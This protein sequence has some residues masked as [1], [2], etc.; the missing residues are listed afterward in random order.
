MS[1][2]KSKDKVAIV[3]LGES[4]SGKS[5]TFYE[6]FNRRLQS[7]YK[8]LDIN[9]VETLV[10]LKNTSFEEMGIEIEDEYFIKHKSFNKYYSQE[11]YK[12]FF[13]E[14]KLPKYIICAVQYQK[15]DR[16][17]DYLKNKGYYLYIQ[18]LNPSFKSK[19]GY[20]DYNKYEEIYSPYG[21]FY[22]ESGLEKDERCKKI[23]DFL[24]N[25]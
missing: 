20:E 3:I 6:I 13:D 25:L 24:K 15:G 19:K 4:N 8:I 14:N 17:L 1:S 7:G 22:K 16:T 21:E 9:G 5:T 2:I 11:K 18:W 12:K 23:K 10:F